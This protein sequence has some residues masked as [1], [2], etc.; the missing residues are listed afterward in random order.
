MA[1]VYLEGD[2]PAAG[3]AKSLASG[4]PY[5]KWFVDHASAVHGIDMRAGAPPKPELY[6]SFDA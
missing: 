5:D 4:Q 3:I 2:D 6:Y 1:A